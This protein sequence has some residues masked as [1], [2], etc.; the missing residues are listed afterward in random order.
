VIKLVQN[1]AARPMS[2]TQAL[3]PA[4][5]PA[6]AHP[7]ALRARGLERRWCSWRSDK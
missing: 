4:V 1:E 2:L 5:S 3:A 7:A 6:V